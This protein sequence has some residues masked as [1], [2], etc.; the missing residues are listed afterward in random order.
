[1]KKNYNELLIKVIAF[2]Q[3]DVITTSSTV[4]VEQDENELP[5]VSFFE[6][7]IN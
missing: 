7:G 6:S 5:F 3:E 4:N 2:Q 1:M